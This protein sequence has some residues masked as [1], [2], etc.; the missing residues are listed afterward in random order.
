MNIHDQL[1]A[2][3]LTLPPAPKPV[4]AYVPAVRAGE[5]VWVSGQLPFESGR[6]LATGPVPSACPPDLASRAAR[7]CCLNALAVLGDQIGGDWGRLVRV[8]RLGVF[9]ASDAGFYEQPRVANGASDLLLA[10]LGEAGRHA[11]AAV[12]V[13]VLPLNASVELEM[14]AQVRG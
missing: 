10:L 7:Q 3:G 6:L 14:V 13:N 4:A 8:L 2:L 1:T 11:R 5:L 9:I 12:G